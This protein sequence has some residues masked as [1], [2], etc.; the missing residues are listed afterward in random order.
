[1]QIHGDPDTGLG[2]H[3]LDH[4][5]GSNIGRLI[6]HFQV[7]VNAVGIPGFRQQGF[8]LCKIRFKRHQGIGPVPHQARRHIPCGW[9]C[10]PVIGCLQDRGNIH[11]ILHCLTNPL[12]GQLGMFHIHAQPHIIQGGILFHRT[13]LRR[14][15]LHVFI[16]THTDA[17]VVQ[18][19]GL[20]PH[21]CG[22]LI[23]N[24]KNMDFVKTGRRPFPFRVARKHGALFGLP[25]LDHIRPG[26]TGRHGCKLSAGRCNR[27]FGNNIASHIGQRGHPQ[28][29]ERFAQNDD[30][31]I[32]ICDLHRFQGGPVPFDGGFK[33]RV[34]DAFIG[35]FYIFGCHFAEPVGKGDARLEHKFDVGGIRLFD[36]LGRFQLPCPLCPG[37]VGNQLVVHRSIDMFL[38][39]IG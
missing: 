24:G 5:A 18:I 7:Q 19:T 4:L 25:F 12:I 33:F 17:G 9:L 27:F 20:K 14:F 39:K 22:F 11:G 36:G 26:K 13:V 23:I 35:E 37:F 10:H 31:R 38:I 28:G 32:F 34:D 6:G 1:V 8:G 2:C 15:F 29:L 3:C 21:F 16:R 30:P